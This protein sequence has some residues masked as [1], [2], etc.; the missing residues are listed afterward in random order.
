MDIKLVSEKISCALSKLAIDAPEIPYKWAD[1]NYYL[2][3]GTTDTPG[4]WSSYG[5]QRGLLGFFAGNSVVKVILKKCKRIGG[6]KCLTAAWA[7]FI[8]EQRR[9]VCIWHPVG[10]DSKDF[11]TDEINPLF[12]VMP[13]L[14]TSLDGDWKNKKER[15]NTDA[16]KKFIGCSAYFRGGNSERAYR[17]ITVSVAILDEADGFIVGAD[18]YAEFI[19]RAYGRTETALNRKLIVNSTVRVKGASV[20]DSAYEES[21]EKIFRD[22][23]CINCGHMHVLE[24]ENFYYT[25]SED[26]KSAIDA[27]FECPHCHGE[28]RYEDYAEMDE[29]GQWI[30]ETGMLY[31]EEN[32]F[33][34]TRDG[35]IVQKIESLGVHIWSAYSYFL[36]WK[37]LASTWIR[38]N[39]AAASG[40]YSQLRTFVN[41]MLAQVYEER[42][43][44]VSATVFADRLEKYHN[45]YLPD[46]VTHLVAGCDIQTGQDARIEVVIVGVGNE[47]EKWHVDH[48]V[49]DGDIAKAKTQERLDEIL[50]RTYK[51]KAGGELPISV[52]LLDEGDGNVCEEVRKYCTAR[53]RLATGETSKKRLIRPCKGGDK[54]NLVDVRGKVYGDNATKTRVKT[55]VINHIAAKDVL[56]GAISKVRKPGKDYIHFPDTLSQDYFN[57]LTGERRVVNRGKVKYEKRT[58]SQRVEVLDCWVYAIAASRIYDFI[59]RK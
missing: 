10:D 15:N 4:P 45:E 33:F 20:T 52:A 53:K 24:W 9:S 29:Q 56:Y 49:L 57:Q 28:L 41:E 12:E 39:L 27:W 23:K 25:K 36:S 1:N 34:V 2:V 46:G 22:I 43:G 13:S 37:E 8:T 21:E 26:G 6:T 40:D 32:D 55:H 59:N 50:L 31:D 47:N 35:G 30:T 51:N 16:K 58:G 5:Y 18:G 54:G 7:K 14:Q 3:K 17:Q 11:V 44:T 48:V 42:S 38:A 19:E